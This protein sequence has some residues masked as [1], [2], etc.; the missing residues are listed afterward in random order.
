[1]SN[2]LEDLAKEITDLALE[3][4]RLEDCKKESAKNYT[5]KIN[6]SKDRLIA[7]SHQYKE[8]SF[9][10]DLFD[11]PSDID[12]SLSSS[13]NSFSLSSFG[14]SMATFA[15][16]SFQSVNTDMDDLDIARIIMRGE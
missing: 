4:E 12:T 2:Y 6:Y 5:D 7:L 15:C 3:I 10:L 9:Q 13:L 14:V 11:K 16:S 8:N 1:M